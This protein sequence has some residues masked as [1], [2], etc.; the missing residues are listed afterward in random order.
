MEYFMESK[1]LDD[2]DILCRPSFDPLICTVSF[3]PFKRN[4]GPRHKNASNYDTPPLD[5][6]H[7]VQWRENP[8][9]FSIRRSG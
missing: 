9:S 4:P 1:I 6:T 3:F 8:L 2:A 7:L 5:E